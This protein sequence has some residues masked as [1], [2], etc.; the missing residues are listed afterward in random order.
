MRVLWWRWLKLLL[1]SLALSACSKPQPAP[2]PKRR[3]SSELSQ[4]SCAKQQVFEQLK[5]AAF[6]KA[7]AVRIGD[8]ETLD[9]L[10]AAAVVRMDRPAASGRDQALN[11]TLCKGRMAI[12]L[13]PGFE[14]AFNGDRQVVAEVEYGVQS[15]ADRTLRAY[16][17]DG[18]EP[19]VYR[20]AAIDLKTIPQP[21]RTPP[22]ARQT[23][24]ASAASQT[25]AN[26]KTST[27]R[28][29]E[30]E[31]RL[32]TRGRP[33]FD[34]RGIRAR[35]DRMVCGDERLA[36]LDRVAASLYDQAMDDSDRE[37]RA[38]L[39]GTQGRFV[40]RRGRCATPACVAA[41]YRDRMDEI[42]RIA[43]EG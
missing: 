13:P 32:T 41:V 7:K 43:S 34:C 14:D 25:T 28:S 40:A 35:V 42:D 33:S 37:T 4:A 1:G 6:E 2:E 26:S 24:A 27:R 3:A 8:T 16:P 5:A 31:P 19:V 22:V 21:A 18:L 11:V 10:G 36:A 17:I 39:S 9:R 20:L 15:T 30:L 38:I 12:D 29:A 23:V